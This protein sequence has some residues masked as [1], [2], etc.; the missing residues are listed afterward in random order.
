M[1]KSNKIEVFISESME[2]AIFSNK[3]ENYTLKGEF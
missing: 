3:L 2:N 1:D